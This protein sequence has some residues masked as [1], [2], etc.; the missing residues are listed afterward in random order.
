MKIR[1]VGAQ[2]SHADRQTDMMNRIAVA[3]NF[4]N[5]SKKKGSNSEQKN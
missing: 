1:P 4:T 2:S 5:A 3:R